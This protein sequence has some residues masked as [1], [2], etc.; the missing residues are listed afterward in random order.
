MLILM[1]IMLIIMQITIIIILTMICVPNDGGG[2]AERL[3]RPAP[4]RCGTS[5]FWIRQ[6][7][8]FRDTARRVRFMVWRVKG[9]VVFWAN[10]KRQY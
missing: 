8:A 6:V 3:R 9:S 4:T 2:R 10:P 1:M 5:G 7:C